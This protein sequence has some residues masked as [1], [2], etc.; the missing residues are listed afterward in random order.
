MT[1]DLHLKAI[2]CINTSL[3]ITCNASSLREEKIR[4]REKKK[5][6]MHNKRDTH[7]QSN[8]CMHAYEILQWHLLGV[9]ILPAMPNQ[10]RDCFFLSQCPTIPSSPV[11]YRSYYYHAVG[12]PSEILHSMIT[13]RVIMTILLYFLFLLYPFMRLLYS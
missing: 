1:H 5:K 6:R 2:C 10:D 4:K 13:S 3:Q 7:Y 11:S 9:V 12:D 8:K